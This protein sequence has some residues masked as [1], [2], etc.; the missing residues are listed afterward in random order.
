MLQ[1]DLHNLYKGADTDNMKF[2]MPTSCNFCD[3]E[4][5]RVCGTLRFPFLL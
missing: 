1:N 2:Y 4:K 5:F 3:M